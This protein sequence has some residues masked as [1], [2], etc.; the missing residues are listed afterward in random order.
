M[1]LPQIVIEFNS[2][3]QSIITRSERQTIKCQ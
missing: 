2:K 3:A 1:K